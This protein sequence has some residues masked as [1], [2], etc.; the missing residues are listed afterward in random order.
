M[1]CKNGVLIRNFTKSQENTCVGVSFLLKL[2]VCT[3]HFLATASEVIKYPNSFSLELMNGVFY[4]H[5]NHYKLRSSNVFTTDNPRNKFVLN[6]TV[7]RANKLWETL[8]SKVKDC[9]SLQLFKHNI[10]AVIVSILLQLPSQCWE[11]ALLLLYSRHMTKLRR[12]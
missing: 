12:F 2:Q 6:A 8:P 7:S 9:P 11:F 4:L 5:Q 1:F 10:G 3:E